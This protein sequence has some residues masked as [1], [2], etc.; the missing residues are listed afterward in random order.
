VSRIYAKKDADSFL[1]SQ[2]LRIIY[3]PLRLPRRFS[4]GKFV[5]DGPSVQGNFENPLWMPYSFAVK[6]LLLSPENSTLLENDINIFFHAEGLMGDVER[7]DPGEEARTIPDVQTLFDEE[8]QGDEH[9]EDVP[10]E[11]RN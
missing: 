3:D 7:D 10:R 4:L 11:A 8:A 1:Q 5:Q 6:R 9:T 2:D